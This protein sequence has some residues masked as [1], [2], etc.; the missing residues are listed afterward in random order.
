MKK[1]HTLVSTGIKFRTDEIDEQ[2]I[3]ALEDN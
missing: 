2:V 3:S 1:H